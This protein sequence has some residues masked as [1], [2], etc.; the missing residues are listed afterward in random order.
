MCT[1]ILL[2]TRIHPSIP[3]TKLS[4]GDITV[5]ERLWRTFL[6]FR[7]DENSKFN[8][9]SSSV[10]FRCVRVT[11]KFQIATNTDTK[12]A[13]TPHAR[14]HTHTMFPSFPLKTSAAT[15]DINLREQPTFP[16]IR[17]K[18]DHE[19]STGAILPALSSCLAKSLVSGTSN[20]ERLWHLFISGIPS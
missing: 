20:G 12:S 9:A 1:R 13:H 17:V 7:T 8:K 15:C 14:T 18:R 3:D 19:P 2:A 4:S 6:T 16:T 5:V 11:V 10:L